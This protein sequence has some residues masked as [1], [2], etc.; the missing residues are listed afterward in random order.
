MTGKKSQLKMTDKMS[1]KN[2]EKM[3]TN[4]IELKLSDISDVRQYEKEREEYRARIIEYKKKRRVHVG[5]FQTFLFEDRETIKFQIQEMA[6]AE[7]ISTDEKIQ[8][9]LDIYNPIISR[10]GKLSATFFIELTSDEQLRE[11]LPKLAGIENM[12]E[13]HI[14]E[15]T[16]KIVLKNQIDS[17]HEETLTR[18][19]TTAC[20]HYL[21][22]EVTP[23]MLE[24]FEKGPV[25]IVCTHPAYQEEAELSDLTRS[26]LI[27]NLSE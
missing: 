21:S 11:W 7:Q 9:E 17:E 8:I 16:E 23:D 10:P 26:E 18:E 27:K 12:Y 24:T 1:R 6:R 5:T 4:T 13:L 20:V 3:T 22:W 14:G 15:G 25:K 19:E 2:K